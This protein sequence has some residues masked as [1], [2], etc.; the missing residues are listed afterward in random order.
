MY[1]PSNLF[2]SAF[3][4]YSRRNLAFARKLYNRLE[5]DDWDI[6][7]DQEDIPPGVD[8]QEEI[9]EGIRCTDNFI[10]IISPDSVV[11]RYCRMEIE[12]AV[13][14]HKRIIPLLNVDLEKDE[15]WA[16]LHPSVGR[17]NW[18]FFVEEDDFDKS[19]R[20]L[21]SIMESHQDYVHQHTLLL[22]HAIEWQKSGRD[23]RLILTRDLRSSAHK[24][25]KTTFVGQAPCTPTK[26]HCEFIAQSQKS[27]QNGSCDV[28]LGQLPYFNELREKVRLSLL[29]VGLTTWTHEFDIKPGAGSRVSIDTGIELSDNVVF[30]INRD[31]IADE[32]SL[33][34]VEYAISLEK[35]IIPI[36]LEFVAETEFPEYLKELQKISF[37][38][39]VSTQSVFINNTPEFALL[40]GILESEKDYLN[41]HKILLN[42]ALKWKRNREIPS[43]LLTG[44]ALELA[45]A[46]L[47]TAQNKSAYRATTLH[48]EFIQKS[49]TDTIGLQAEIYLSYS[50]NDSEYA[51]KINEELQLA[52]RITWFD[53]ENVSQSELHHENI[54]AC[55][56][57]LFIFSKQSLDS[58]F[59]LQEIEYAFSKHK[60]IIVLQIEDTQNVVP[61]EI[62]IF[63][64]L[65]VIGLSTSETLQRLLVELDSNREYL[66]LFA[67]WQQKANQWKASGKNPEFLLRAAEMKE[68]KAWYKQALDNE[69]QP[70]PTDTIALYLD[71]SEMLIMVQKEL[72]DKRQNELLHLEMQKARTEQRFQRLLTL[73]STVVLL[74]IGL[75]A[76]FSYRA[77]HNSKATFTNRYEN[78]VS[79]MADVKAKQIESIFSQ[80]GNSLELLRNTPELTALVEKL[81]KEDESKYFALEK[82]I[83]HSLLPLQKAY[84]Y[85]D[86]GISN[87]NGKVLFKVNPNDATLVRGNFL[88][89]FKDAIDEFSSS[90][91]KEPSSTQYITEGTR[92]FMLTPIESNQNVIGVYVAVYDLKSNIYPLLNVENTLG[93]TGEIILSSFFD[94]RTS[95]KIISP[96][97]FKYEKIPWVVNTLNSNNASHLRATRQ[98]TGPFTEFMKDYRGEEALISGLHIPV[99]NWGIV[100]KIDRRAMHRD[101]K[102]F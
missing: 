93:E 45:K 36:V 90:S 102:F 50:R 26:L 51:R 29:R 92:V 77:Y 30:F 88:L 76:V 61:L 94:N 16:A 43:L 91:S 62:K 80:M 78:L 86:I 23:E 71:E 74:G 64:I 49:I 75:F 72:E 99:V 6:W 79:V 58:K 1:K 73:A 24:W 13:K 55:L 39:L 12:I 33:K 44:R 81:E 59:C 95:L 18:L 96:L 27:A 52:G 34:E 35:R 65:N 41:T 57:V 25:L 40:L 47:A 56:N 38:N 84:N 54:D 66:E 68:A 2:T 28:F 98:S 46:W 100:V 10:F 15:E 11:S 97:K 19:Y 63:N 9:E 8:F 87:R 48:S 82:Q 37:E 89:D 7:F 22:F 14:Y 3:I 53:Q 83:S 32:K 4:S 67:R 85:L 21:L 42:Q 17:I 5:S 70:K 31:S 60:K 101:F 69:T 20:S